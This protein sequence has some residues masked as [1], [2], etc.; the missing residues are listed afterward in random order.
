MKV[1]GRSNY[2]SG[3]KDEC[4]SPPY[5]IMPL[6]KHIE[7]HRIKLGLKRR[8]YAIY[9][10]AT[11]IAG[12]THPGLVNGL[13]SSG[14]RVIWFPKVNFF[15]VSFDEIENKLFA[16]PLSLMITN[17]PYSVGL[18]RAFINKFERWHQEYGV[19]YALL[20]TA[21]TLVEKINGKTLQGCSVHVP[22]GRINYGMPNK[23]WG[24]PENPTKATFETMWYS[25]GL[26]PPRTITYDTF[27]M[28]DHYKSLK[29]F[30]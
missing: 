23:G 13:R 27:D 30:V 6:I 21:T 5:A 28:S 3:P 12:K 2:K 7:A 10:P 8:D 4:A 22:N 20:M 29:N 24:T 16:L 14:Y 19:P 26:T 18:K 1:K 11:G 17:P 25:K 9:E 15:D